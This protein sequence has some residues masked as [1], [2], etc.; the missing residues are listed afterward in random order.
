VS[1]AGVGAGGGLGDVVEEF[2]GRTPGMVGQLHG[3]VELLRN[4]KCVGATA[5]VWFSRGFGAIG[6]EDS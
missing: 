1:S 5:I 2:V 4:A 6:W 3:A